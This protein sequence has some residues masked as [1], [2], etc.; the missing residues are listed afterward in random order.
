MEQNFKNHTR[1]ITGYHRVLALFLLS[2]L[3]GS[4][5][6]LIES[7]GTDNLYSA[8][9][10][11]LL[12]LCCI[13]LYWYVRVFPLKAQDR[14]IRAEEN[15]RHYILSGKPLPS[16]LRIS[17]IVAL[18]FASDEEFLELVQKAL[19]ENMTNKAIKQVIKIWKPDYHRV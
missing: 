14:A 18:R 10:L 16:E 15:F 13:M 1:L 8:S 11:V 9:L 2:G 4:I 5:I 6:N 12:F 17:Q 19:K 3:I 7:S